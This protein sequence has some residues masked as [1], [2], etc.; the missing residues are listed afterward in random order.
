[1]AATAVIGTTT[2]EA[3]DLMHSMLWQ[4]TS[5][6]VAALLA[7]AASRAGAESITTARYLEPTGRYGHFSLGR[8][9][10]YTRV[11]V[12]TDSGRQL[13]FELPDNEV[14]EDLAP[15]RVRMAPGAP[16]EL[17]TIVSRR[18]DGARLVM[19]R[20]DGDRLDI[21]AQTPP[22]GTP[23]RWLNPVGVADLD[24]DGSSEVAMVSTPHIGGILRVFRRERRQLVEVASLAGFSNHVYGSTELALS[25]HLVIGGQTRLLVPD[26]GRRNL[27][28]I[29]L[30]G[31]RLVET[32]RCALPAQITDAIRIVSADEVTVG[33]AGGRHTVRLDECTGARP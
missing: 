27:R 20:L 13:D 12:T 31:R 5:F 21:S 25:T 14:F 33:L 30:Q 24:G 26:F 3:P 16:V 32:G 28:I 9:H 7:L 2:R 18:Q 8:P 17:L 10:E 29:A 4:R 19:L 22:V 11:V 1:M 15:R 6:L 23:M